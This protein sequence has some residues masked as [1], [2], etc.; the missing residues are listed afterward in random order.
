VGQMWPATTF[1][2]ARGSIQEICSSLNIL[3]TYHSKCYCLLL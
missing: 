1:S 2:V 3:P